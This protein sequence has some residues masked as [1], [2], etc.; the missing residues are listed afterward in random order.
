MV[1]DTRK[2]AQNVVKAWNLVQMKLFS[3]RSRI[4]L[5]ALRNSQ[6]L[7]YTIVAATNTGIPLKGKYSRK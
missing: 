4:D 2:I 7:F 1:A 6:L 3:C 5:R